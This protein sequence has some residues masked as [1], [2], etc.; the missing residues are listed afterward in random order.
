MIDQS[1]ELRNALVQSVSSE[2]ITDSMEL[3]DVHD[4]DE[5]TDLLHSLENE[6]EAITRLKNVMLHY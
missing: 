1:P 6:L 3:Q 5:A 2:R 4:D